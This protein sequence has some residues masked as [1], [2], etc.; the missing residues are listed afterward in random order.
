MMMKKINIKKPDFRSIRF[1]GGAYTAV[2]SFIAI[3]L[4]VVINLVF[5]KLNITFD[6][7]SR[8]LYSIT[9]ET[10]EYLK[11]LEDDITIYYLE[12]EGN[13]IDMFDKIL[14]QFEKA[15]DRVKVV[16]KDPVLYPAFASD[17]TDST[18]T[19]YALIVVNESNG[20]YRYLA[21]E[22]Y[23]I[24]EYSIDY[25]TYNYEANT[26][27]LDMEGQIDSAI[28]YVTSDDMAK[29]YQVTGH[30]EEALGEETTKQIEKANMEVESLKLMTVDSV[31]EDCNVLFIQ[32][33]QNDLTEDEAALLKEY[34]A[35]GGEAVI[36]LSYMD[37]YHPNLMG[38]LG[39]YGVT[40]SDGIIIDK[41]NR[42]NKTYPAYYF[43]ANVT[44]AEIN[45]GIYNEKYVVSQGSS[46][47]KTDTSAD[48]LYLTNLLYTS[49]S[50][51]LKK[52]DA[53]TIEKE[54]GDEEGTF[55]F[56]CRIDN[57]STETSICV[58][59]GLGLFDD[60][61]ANKSSYGNT[62]L[63]INSIKALTGSKESSMVIRAI[64]F[65]DTDYLSIPS[66]SLA[67]G[68]A[69]VLILIPV[70]ILI[71]GI[72]VVIIRRKRG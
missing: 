58:F 21:E 1:K 11:G 13:S 28:D 40:L 35:A 46:A 14:E 72:V 31:P 10:K 8:E 39:E 25:S 70:V 63:L 18:E 67:L 44:A 38:V 62:N 9:D 26:T 22:D 59:S 48:N 32:T 29:I 15:S 16:V 12:P 34:L 4:A 51:Y 55:Y 33:P 54:E 53:P 69:G 65:T 49:G 42:M 66:A 43:I 30:G 64:D 52:V 7:T 50:A 56:G 71:T 27:G 45:Q 36:N 68:L 17:Y 20:K 19:N 41:D 5:I 47:I 2:F 3:V 60:T 37:T 57:T 23:V 6:L 61:F 24:V